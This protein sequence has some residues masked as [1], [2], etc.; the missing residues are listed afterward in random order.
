MKDMW[1]NDVAVGDRVRLLQL[2]EVSYD[3]EQYKEVSAMLGD[4]FILESIEYECVQISRSF[5]NGNR[6]HTLFLWP[7][8]FELVKDAE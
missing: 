7:A 5:D 1:G 6:C 3:K 8:E 2:P 4:C